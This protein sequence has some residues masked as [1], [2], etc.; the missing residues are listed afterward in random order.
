[1]ALEVPQGQVSIGWLE[2]KCFCK[3]R[4]EGAP[5]GINMS[6]SGPVWIVKVGVL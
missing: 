3:A 4:G 2:L 5:V 1:M 6:T